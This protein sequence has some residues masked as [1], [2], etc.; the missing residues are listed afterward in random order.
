MKKFK[1]NEKLCKKLTA[2]TLMTTMTFSSAS[3]LPIYADNDNMCYTYEVLTEYDVNGDNYVVEHSENNSIRVTQKH[4]K[5]ENVLT[6][7]HN[8]RVTII[9]QNGFLCKKEEFNINEFNGTNLQINENCIKNK[10]LKQCVK[11]LENYFNTNSF[12]NGNPLESI[13]NNLMF[14]GTYGLSNSD[15]VKLAK[16]QYDDVYIDYI[17]KIDSKNNIDVT[18]YNVSSAAI[19]LS[20]TGTLMTGGT[21]DAITLGA[22]SLTGPQVVLVVVAV[23]G[24]LAADYFIDNNQIYSIDDI[25]EQDILSTQEV[26][27]MGLVTVTSAME[28]IKENYND[29]NQ[30]NDYYIA[31]LCNNGKVYINF[32]NPLSIDEAKDVLLMGTPEQNI[33]SLT[34]DQASE[35]IWHSGGIP[36]TS[37][38]DDRMQQKAECHAYSNSHKSF[39]VVTKTI[40]NDELTIDPNARKGLYYWH[41]HFHGKNVNDKHS[42][43]GTPVKVK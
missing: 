19:P 5:G 23:A 20:L 3:K 35:V 30:N 27:A 18:N 25:F 14:D 15:S 12:Y 43:F 26:K 33:Y 1:I 31:Y 38:S 42:F 40:D 28:G 10:N 34:A 29:D 22:S 2:Y 4:S 16:K 21:M 8:G 37:S 17:N 9:T 41:Y 6:I 32:I 11:T 13:N 24:L 7:D 39:N 36:G